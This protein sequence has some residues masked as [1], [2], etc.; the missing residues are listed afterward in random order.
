MGLLG[1]GRSGAQRCL[2][3]RLG[4]TEA[5]A[6]VWAAAA[7]E[8]HYEPVCAPDRNLDYRP[9]LIQAAYTSWPSLVVKLKR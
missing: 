9:E 6:K 8:K 4:A 1:L 5:E 3:A 2:L 7:A